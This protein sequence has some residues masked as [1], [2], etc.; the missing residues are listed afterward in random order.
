MFSD[1]YGY[2][3]KYNQMIEKINQTILPAPLPIY[4][5]LHVTHGHLFLTSV[6]ETA[7]NKMLNGSCT[8][9]LLPLFL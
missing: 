2:S 8:S 6:K 4:H 5:T 9:L 1:A 7:Q 3:F